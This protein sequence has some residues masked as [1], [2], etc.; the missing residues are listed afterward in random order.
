MAT[1]VQKDLQGNVII[2]AAPS[3]G[4]K[5]SLVNALLKEDADI[6]LS[7]SCT[8]RAP[9]PGEQDGEH[10]YFIDVARFEEL[11]DAEELLEWA[12]VHGNYYG[13]PAQPI[14][15][16]LAS[17]KDVILEIDWQG[18]RQVRTFFP[19][20]I[21]VFILP[22]SIEV[23]EERLRNRGQ[24]S[25]SVI[26]RRLLAAGGEM[27]HVSEFQYVIINQD[28]N[29]ALNDLKAIVHANR[30]RTENQTARHAAVFHQL[31]IS[32]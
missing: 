23:L 27:A 6:Q 3:G 28:F 21:G 13:T 32:T 25:D 15:D 5:S 12:N 26:A 4:G 7:V 17:G 16:L 22:P 30:L 10:Y 9:R 24:D 11:R 18:A 2:V 19:Q 20:A 1:T 14:K 29:T 31:G 8:T